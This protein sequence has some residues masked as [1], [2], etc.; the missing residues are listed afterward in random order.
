[1]SVLEHAHCPACGSDQISGIETAW[2]A[3]L[4][5]GIEPPTRRAARTGAAPFYGGGC[6]MLAV[7]IVGGAMVCASI[8]APA[9]RIVVGCVLLA[10]ALLQVLRLVGGYPKP[11]ADERA[12]NA[13]WRSARAEWQ[14]TW[15]CL[16]CGAVF[17]LR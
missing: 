3:G 13:D 15:L 2:K 9:V 10:G 1:M 12:A 4:A 8:S 17:V 16:S 11:T 5:D 6:L 7:W 14:R